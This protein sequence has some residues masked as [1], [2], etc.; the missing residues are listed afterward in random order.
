MNYPEIDIHTHHPVPAGTGI[1]SYRVGSG[2]PLPE[3]PYSAGIHPWDAG[4]VAVEALTQAITERTVAIGEIGL[5]YARK[6]MPP[7]AMQVRVFRAQLETAAAL[8][9]PVIIHCVKAYDDLF[10]MLKGFR[11][12]VIIH[13]F[14]GSPELARQCCD[15]GYYLS[16]GE[17]LFRSPKTRRALASI[18]PSQL[19]LETDDSDRRIA[20]LYAKAA[21]IRGI[22]VETLRKILFENYERLFANAPVARTHRTAAGS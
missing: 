18:P 3:A 21:E 16:F 11:Q 19:F 13:G 20:E 9:L 4:K 22:T 12:P 5:D 10:S 6:E 8:N 7:P 14:T 2:R 17:N 1:P 15:A